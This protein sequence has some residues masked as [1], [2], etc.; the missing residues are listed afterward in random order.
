MQNNETLKFLRHF[1]PL[2]ILKIGML[3][4]YHNWILQ[5]G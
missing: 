3:K 5:T 1:K 2:R 4:I